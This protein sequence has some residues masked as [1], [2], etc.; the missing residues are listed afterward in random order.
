LASELWKFRALGRYNF[1]TFETS[2]RQPTSPVINE[3]DQNLAIYLIV[4]VGYVPLLN[5]DSLPGHVVMRI[6]DLGTLQGL[7]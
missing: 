5:L 1:I 6:I 4:N 7:P 2:R 3:V